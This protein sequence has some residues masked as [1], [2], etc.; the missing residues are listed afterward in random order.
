MREAMLIGLLAFVSI[1]LG[2]NQAPSPP[3]GDW[4]HTLWIDGTLTAI[5]SI[6][7]GKSHKELDSLFEPEGGIHARAEGYVYIYKQCPYIKV[8]VQFT[9]DGKIS[10]I[11]RP[12][13]ERPTRA[14]D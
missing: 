8:N 13:L 9:N 14:R 4:E 12:Y 11:S 10:R 7:V 3:K 1:L 6:E 2:Q 5:E